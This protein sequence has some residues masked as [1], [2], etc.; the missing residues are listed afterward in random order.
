M[1]LS[2]H[3]PAFLPWPGYFDKI[4]KADVFVILDDVQFERNSFV[5]RNLIKINDRA[6]WLTIPLKMKGHTSKTIR[7]MEVDQSTDW[8]R[9]AEKTIYHAYHRSPFCIS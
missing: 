2:A 3:Q 6:L 5:N 8:W 4:N 1:V 7:Q 9:N